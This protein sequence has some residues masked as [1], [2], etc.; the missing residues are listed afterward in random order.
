M[1]KLI[2]QSNEFNNDDELFDLIKEVTEECKT[3]EEYKQM[4]LRPVV[5]LP[6]S[7]RFN[8]VVCMDLKI[9]VNNEMYI[10]HFIDTA[11]RY[12]NAVFIKTKEAK[13]IIKQVYSQ[14]IKFFGVPSKFL[15]DNGGEFANEK[16]REMNERLNVETCTTAA[17]SPFSNGM[18]ERHNLILYE[19]CMKL[20][21]DVYNVIQTSL[22]V[23]ELLQK[24]SLQNHNGFSSNQLVFGRNPNLPSVL[25]DD[26][27]ALESTTTTCD[28]IR[29]NMEAM[30]KARE[31]FIKTES[32]ERIRRALR[33]KVRTYSNVVYKNGD[34]VYY[35]RKQ[36]KGWKGPATVLGKDG[37]C[38]KIK[39]GSEYCRVHP[40]HL[41]KKNVDVKKVKKSMNK[42]HSHKSDKVSL[43]TA[44]TVA[45]IAGTPHDDAESDDQQEY[46][47]DNFHEV[48]INISDA[49]DNAESE[50]TSDAEFGVENNYSNGNEIGSNIEENEP[51]NVS[52]QGRV[53]NEN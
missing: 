40:C 50:T 18:V 46:D 48:D 37:Q 52:N 12:S 16:F 2:K 10:L 31:A 53:V 3:C 4:K 39:H 51:D 11:T 24:N 49:D 42:V 17:E 13:E 33:H 28:I 36:Y 14:W 26:L 19:C 9:Y 5:G 6:L 44:S 22:W 34:K 1:I 38:V 30:H 20:S 27:P 23:W 47:T 43:P 29:Q 32:S 35:K 25:V 21:N 7:T 15:T 41:L 45:D 8:E